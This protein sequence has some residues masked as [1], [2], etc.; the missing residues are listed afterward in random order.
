MKLYKNRK[1]TKKP[2]NE[3]R[4]NGKKNTKNAKSL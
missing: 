4:E 3:T 2:Q 1:Q